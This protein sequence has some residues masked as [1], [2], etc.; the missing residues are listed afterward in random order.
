[1]N[2]LLTSLKDLE[3]LV[4]F[5]I[6]SLCLHFFIYLYQCS[7]LYKVNKLKYNK[8]SISVWIPYINSY[9]LGKLI[10]NKTVGFL[11]I[12]IDFLLFPVLPMISLIE[13]QSIILFIFMISRIILLLY[14]KFAYSDKTLYFDLDVPSMNDKK[15][16]NLKI[17]KVRK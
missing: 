17:K 10:V 4:Y 12:V 5:F 11:L 6:I 2:F 7:L 16:V 14:G 15:K 3:I 9:M 13:L 1:M 8:E